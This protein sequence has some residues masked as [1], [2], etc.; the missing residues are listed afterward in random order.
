M[1]YFSKFPYLVTTNNDRPIFIQDFLRRVALGVD[2]TQN[3]V[4]LDEYLVLDGETPEMVSQK[5]YSRPSYH[6]VLLLVNNITDPREEWPIRDGKVTDLVYQ[7]YD[8]TLT[9][10]SGSAYNIDDVITSDT[11]GKFLVTSKSSNTVYLRSQ[12]GKTIITTSSI[13]TNTTT[14]VENL[15]VTAVTDPEEAVHH[16]YDPEIGY[17]VSESF[18]GTTV[19]VTNYEHEIN[20]N[21]AKRNIKIL[22]PRFLSSFVS[23]FTTKIN[24]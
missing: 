17:I 7:K 1:E 13:L 19:P 24:S 3:V 12:V 5:F 2:F 14:E 11:D 23:E 16:Y 18:S 9:V 10:P 8:F 6:W 15:T 20:V 21:D 22:N 4:G